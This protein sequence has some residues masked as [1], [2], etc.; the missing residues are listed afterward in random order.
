MLLLFCSTKVYVFGLNCSNCLGTGDSTSTIVPKKLD[1]LS[2]KK[3]VSLSY[4]SGPHVL[5]ATD[6]KTRNVESSTR[7]GVRTEGRIVHLVIA[8][9]R[10]RGVG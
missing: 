4:G 6:G 10:K 5:L 7:S 8:Q 1:C 2:G 3:V 9:K